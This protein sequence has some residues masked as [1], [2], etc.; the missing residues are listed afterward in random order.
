MTT[1]NVGEVRKDLYNLVD[2]VHDNH[3]ALVIKGKRHNAV[4]LSENNWLALQETLHLVSQ[5][6]MRDSIIAGMKESIDVCQNELS[7]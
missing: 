7:W 4:L 2:A 3:D 6:G 1:M 5:P